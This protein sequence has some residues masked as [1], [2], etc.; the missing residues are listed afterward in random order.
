M[1]QMN[2]ATCDYSL[3]TQPAHLWAWPFT[4]YM[5]LLVNTILHICTYLQFNIGGKNT[6]L[7]SSHPL[8]FTTD[9][10]SAK[11][12]MPSTANMHDVF[13]CLGTCAYASTMTGSANTQWDI[14]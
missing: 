6:E 7:L 8:P 3:Y 5:T 1:S 4:S 12:L 2:C 9:T 10:L 11:T 14:I 13:E